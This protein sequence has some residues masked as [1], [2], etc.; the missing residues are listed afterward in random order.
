MIMKKFTTI[1][2]CAIALLTMTSCDWFKLDNLDGYDASVEGRIIDQG[3]NE[4][5]QMEQGAN[6]SVYELYGVQYDHTNQQGEKGWDGATPISWAVKNNG[7][8][9]NKLT[10]AGDYEME[11][12]NLNFLADRVSFQLQKGSNTVDFKVTPYVRIK[13]VQLSATS[14]N[15]I[16]AKCDVEAGVPGTTIV[17]VELCVYPDR[18]VRHSLNKCQDDPKAIVK[19]PSSLTGISLEV[20]P[21][22]I[23]VSNGTERKVNADEFQYNRPHYIRIA[24]LGRHSQK[25]GDAYNYSAVYKLENGSITEVTDW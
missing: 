13:N 12:R 4:L 25:T 11:T 1:I 14:A 2:S 8:Y 7:T 15:V 23:V 16:T 21:Q 9:V 17:A 3:T 6:L 10:F 5:V 20:D 24:A 19:N 22:R 18:W